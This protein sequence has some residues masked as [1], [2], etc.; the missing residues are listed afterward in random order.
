MGSEYAALGIGGGVES[1]CSGSE[2]SLSSA[3]SLGGV[4]T[5]KPIKV[6]AMG[7]MLGRPVPGSPAGSG[8]GSGG[9]A[10]D[11]LSASPGSGVDSGVGAGGAADASGAVGGSE[12]ARGVNDTRSGCSMTCVTSFESSKGFWALCALCV[13][14][15]SPQSV[16]ISSVDGGVDGSMAGASLARRGGTEDDRP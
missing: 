7:R 8:V 1:R 3:S 16:S 10:A 14:E 9:G 11:A 15:T 5:G 12:G 6:A 4:G 2:G 13:S